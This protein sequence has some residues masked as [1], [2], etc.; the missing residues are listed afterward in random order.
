[1]LPV[2]P[3]V[4]LEY[5]I[6]RMRDI[7]MV[8]RALDHGEDV[9]L[10]DVRRTGKTTVGMCALELSIA[11][12]NLVFSVDLA[13]GAPSSLDV[14]ERLAVQ[15]TGH[16]EGWAAVAHGTRAGLAWLHE[17]G[18][19]ALATLD[20]ELRAPVEAVLGVLRAARPDGASQI[21]ATIDE[22][23]ALARS[24]GCSAVVF[25]DEIQEIARWEDS[26]QAQGELRARLRRPGGHLRFLFAGSQPSLV[27]TLFRRDGALDFQGLEQPLAPISSD[28]WHDGL[29]RAFDLLGCEIEDRAID[30]ILEA[31]GGHP[32]RTMLAARETHALAEVHRTP[33]AADYGIAVVAVD[34][35]RRT[36]LWQADELE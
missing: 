34:R 21:A 4:A 36:H 12:G 1:M 18:R 28:D 14:A 7:E 35:A 29:R 25:L 31:S 16:R 17:R 24:R 6:G 11:E 20:P 5:Q 15:L 26:D 30:E 2:G 22:I 33:P 8:R 23:E 13:E 10:V 32:M 9:V 19:G 27:E 3:P